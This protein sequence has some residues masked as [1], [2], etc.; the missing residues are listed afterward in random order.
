[1][2]GIDLISL[3]DEILAHVES[4]FPE[5]DIKD[6]DVLDDEY[7]LRVSNKVKPFIVLR[8]GGLSRDQQNTSF[9][10]VRHDEYFSKVD[11]IAIAPKGRIARRL[12]GYFMDGLIGWRISNGAELTPELGESVV[13]IGEDNAV[14]HLYLAIGTLSFRFNS[15]NPSANITP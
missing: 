14:P 8:W 2:N 3:Q 9:A 5:Y 13:P 15:T 4:S 6:D 7:L 11:I 12:L 10:G 1:M